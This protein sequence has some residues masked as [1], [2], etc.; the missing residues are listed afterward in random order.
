MDWMSW[1]TWTV[2][3][4]VLIAVFAIYLYAATESS[5]VPI[6]PEPASQNRTVVK[7]PGVDPVHEEWLEPQSGSYNSRRNLFAFPV[8]PPPPQPPPPPPPPDRDGDGIPDYQDNCPDVPNPDQADLDG[9]GIGTACDE[10]E[11]APPPPPPPKPVP[12]PFPYRYIGTFG[13][14]GNPIATFARDG[15]I[16]NARIGDVIDGKFVLRNIGLESVDIGFVGFPP[17]E[18]RRVPIGQ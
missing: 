2:I 5:S 13:T 18:R 16:V 11:V 9:D 10:N 8:P 14:A 7:T 3:G 15:Q 4:A 12:P 17:D 1:K 6:D